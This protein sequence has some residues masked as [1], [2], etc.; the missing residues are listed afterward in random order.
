MNAPAVN[1]LA[2]RA[3]AT[4]GGNWWS[5]TGALAT[6]TLVAAYASTAYRLESVPAQART[7][8]KLGRRAAGQ[9][10]PVGG[11]RAGQ[12]RSSG[13]TM[14]AL[15]QAGIAVTHNANAQWQQTRAHPVAEDQ[16]AAPATSCFTPALTAHLPPRAT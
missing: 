13:L 16:L 6:A 7:V 2:E 12:L 1:G 11:S 4:S 8:V 5:P 14:A 10:L 9:A 3:R 15:A